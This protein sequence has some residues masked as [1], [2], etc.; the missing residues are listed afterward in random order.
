MANINISVLKDL[1]CITLDQY[2]WTGLTVNGETIKKDKSGGYKWCQTGKSGGPVKF[3]ATADGLE[4][5][6][7]NQYLMLEGTDHSHYAKLE[8]SLKGKP[9]EIYGVLD[10]YPLAKDGPVTFS[11]G[12]MTGSFEEG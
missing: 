6:N 2:E 12:M 8:Y 3:T 11:Q 5:V 9:F 4:V 1:Y 10:S 7:D